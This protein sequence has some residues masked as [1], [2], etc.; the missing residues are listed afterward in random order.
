MTCYARPPRTIN[1][2]VTT[3]K[4]PLGHEMKLNFVS[5]HDVW[6]ELHYVCKHCGAPKRIWP[7]TT[8]ELMKQFK[9]TEAPTESVYSASAFLELP[10]AR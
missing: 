8:E 4:I 3:I 2:I 10:N 5:D 7:V 9:L 6:W 1:L